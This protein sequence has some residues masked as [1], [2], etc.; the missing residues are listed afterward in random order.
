MNPL[1]V[2]DDA[3]VTHVAQAMV[4]VVV[5]GPPVIGD[6]VDID[7]PLAKVQLAPAEVKHLNVLEAVSAHMRR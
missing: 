5:I 2:S 6:V 3:L 4:P 7:T 1:L